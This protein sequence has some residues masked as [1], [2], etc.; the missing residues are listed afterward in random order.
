VRNL[1]VLLL[2]S[3]FLLTTN[4]CQRQEEGLVAKST[5]KKEKP[6]PQITQERIDIWI[7]VAGEI[8]EYI[9][10]FS[11]EGEDVSE[12]RSLTMLSHSSQRTQVAYGKIFEDA[13]LSS[14]EFW[15][16]MKEMK[17]VRQYFEIKEE[18]EQQVRDLNELIATGKEEIET[19]KRERGEDK[20][21]ETILAM[22]EK[23]R[24]FE[25]FKGDISPASVGIRADLILL[26]KNNGDRI[27]KAISDMW[28]VREREVVPYKH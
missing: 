4:A 22:E 18:E 13:R 3:F 27:N 26:W 16:I 9:R 28:K 20:S 7:K 5:E 1:T 21:M 14:D 6:L 25:G 15:N 8:G 23:I 12:K 2:A 17:R 19:L 24:E 10:K 11:L